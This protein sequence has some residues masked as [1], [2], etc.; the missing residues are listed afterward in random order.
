MLCH[1]LFARINQSI[2]EP[3]VA[4]LASFEWRQKSASHLYG[5]LFFSF[6]TYGKALKSSIRII[7][8]ASDIDFM[9]VWMY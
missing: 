1:Y 3:L 8:A 6:Y 7:S 2:F 5:I 9:L 4:F